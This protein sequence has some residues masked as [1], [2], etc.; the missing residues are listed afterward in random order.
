MAKP[1]GMAVEHWAT[2]TVVWVV[3]HLSVVFERLFVLVVVNRPPG[4]VRNWAGL[5]EVREGG[6]CMSGHIGTVQ[7]EK[8]SDKDLLCNIHTLHARK[9]KVWCYK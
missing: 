2:V 7:S 1:R 9:A 5:S 3:L 8:E 6:T 4:Q